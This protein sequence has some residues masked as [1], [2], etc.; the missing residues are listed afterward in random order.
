[1]RGPLSLLCLSLLACGAGEAT[2][3]ATPNYGPPA[4]ELVL[5]D[6]T[7]LDMAAS[8]LEALDLALMVDMTLPWQAHVQGIELAQS[9]CPD[10]YIPGEDDDMLMG[11]YA[12]AD[13]CRT[14]GGLGYA[15]G[16]G[17]SSSLSL[18]GDLDDPVG[19]TTQA[20]RE[21]VGDGVIDDNN[22]VLLEFDGEALDSYYAVE[23]TDYTRWVY[24]AQVNAT[25]TGNWA[26]GQSA[27][28]SGWRQESYVRYSV[29]EDDGLEVRG[30]LYLFEDRMG[31]FDSF[32]MDFH[33]QGI[34]GAAPGECNLEPQGYIAL[35][36]SSAYW[37]EVIFL[38]RYESGTSDYENPRSVC[39]GCGTLYI[40]GV[41][42]GEVCVDFNG[43]WQGLNPPNLDDILLPIR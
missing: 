2:P 19:L 18:E 32:S 4:E 10:F 20:S 22:G 12:W 30:N 8:I 41:E 43:L 28:P 11:D 16:L 42:Q 36:D 13:R 14:N 1:M 6:T 33:L 3:M 25:L 38:P 26:A 34:A 21:L 27:F 37:Y 39:E 7:D 35:R 29:G 31:R 40:R 5:P 23:A 24:A 17:W 9:G 15:G